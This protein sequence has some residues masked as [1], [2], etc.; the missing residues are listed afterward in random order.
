MG[1]LIEAYALDDCTESYFH[2]I[3]YCTTLRLMKCLGLDLMVLRQYPYKPTGTAPVYLNLEGA[4]E[5]SEHLRWP[6]FIQVL[7]CPTVS[8]SMKILG[9]YNYVSSCQ[10]WKMLLISLLSIL[11]GLNTLLLPFI[12]QILCKS[13]SLD[14]LWSCLPCLH[15]QHSTGK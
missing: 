10:L 14:S 4:V 15:Y 8:S 6:S 3:S 11:T 5:L 12:M 9:I 13:P 1:V 7:I 2:Y